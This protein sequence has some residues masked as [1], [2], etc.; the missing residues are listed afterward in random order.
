[1]KGWIHFSFSS[2]LLRNAVPPPA[3]GLWLYK[4]I[5]LFIFN[6]ISF[7]SV[8]L[9]TCSSPPSYLAGSQDSSPS[10]R[11]ISSQIQVT[12][13]SYVANKCCILVFPLV[14]K[15]QNTKYI[16]SILIN[17][18]HDFF[19]TG[20]QLLCKVHAELA[21]PF[22]PQLSVLQ[23]EHVSAFENTHGSLV[24]WDKGRPRSHLVQWLVETSEEFLREMLLKEIPTAGLQSC[25][26]S[27]M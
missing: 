11:H 4:F 2:K 20:L 19:C 16:L 1:M 13:S 26:W 14:Y 17:L 8:C 15:S 3:D 24:G 18:A 9:L 25:N 21:L 27:L 6:A 22:S 5:Y 10:P 7:C 23:S 12:T